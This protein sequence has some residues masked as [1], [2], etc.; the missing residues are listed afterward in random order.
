M[1][2]LHHL[3][4][5]RYETLPGIIVGVESSGPVPLARFRV[6]TGHSAKVAAAGQWVIGEPVEV[7]LAPARDGGEVLELRRRS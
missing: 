4:K 6:L 7:V 3:L 1:D 2:A 5:Y